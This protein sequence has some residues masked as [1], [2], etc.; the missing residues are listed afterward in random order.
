MALRRKWDRRQGVAYMAGKRSTKGTPDLYR[1][2]SWDPG[3]EKLSSVPM[4]C[5]QHKRSQA[6]W[7]ASCPA[8]S[9]Y[10]S[11]V[12][13]SQGGLLVLILT[14]PLFC[15]AQVHCAERFP[16]TSHS[17]AFQINVGNIFSLSGSILF[18]WDEKDLELRGKHPRNLVTVNC[19]AISKRSY[20]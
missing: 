6:P 17:P 12:C 13:Q 10:P 9:W 16:L 18:V 5:G 8:S 19:R 14:F 3:C 11:C 1:T 7:R 2:A 4:R 15:S 20:W